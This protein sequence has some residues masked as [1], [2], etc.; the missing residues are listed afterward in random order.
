MIAYSTA[1]VSRHPMAAQYTQKIQSG[2]G[3]LRPDTPTRSDRGRVERVLHLLAAHLWPRETRWDD[4]F[5][6]DD[7]ECQV[8][9][10]RAAIIDR[11]SPRLAGFR[12]MPRF[13]LRMSSEVRASNLCPLI[14]AR[15]CCPSCAELT[16]GALVK[17]GDARVRVVGARPRV[18]DE[19]I[20]SG[21]PP[22]SEAFVL[23]SPKE[24][25]QR[26]E[27]IRLDP[28]RRG[29]TIRHGEDDL[30]FVVDLHTDAV[31]CHEVVHSR[32]PNMSAARTA[33]VTPFGS[34]STRT[35]YPSTGND[36]SNRENLSTSAAMNARRSP[37]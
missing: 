27:L 8:H 30:L 19:P 18:D 13:R 21:P 5:D 34:R 17:D 37:Q 28:Q 24:L 4:P 22:P 10:E 20:V 35:Q 12:V 11:Q 32:T 23:L 7:V 14:V 15:D 3:H 33:T 31:G 25:P 1:N 2:T 16:P 26:V 36:A 9:L 29:R 6:S